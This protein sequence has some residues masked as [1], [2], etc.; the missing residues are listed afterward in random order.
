MVGRDSE[1]ERRMLSDLQAETTEALENLRDLA[2][3]IYP[4]LLA[5]RGLVAALEAQARKS[6]IAVQVS[7]ADIGR[8]PQEAETACYFCC[9]EALQNVGKYAHASLAI[10]ELGADDGQLT[11]SVT[12]DGEGF[13]PKATALGTGLQGMVDRVEALGGAL[14]VRSQQG[15]GTTIVGR[16]PARQLDPVG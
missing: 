12:D 15:R 11:F 9:L 1:K 7:A 16:I 14:E 10:V 2:R 4:P 13:D 6:P 5:D 8:Y 3:G